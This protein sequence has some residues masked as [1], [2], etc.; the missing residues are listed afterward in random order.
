MIAIQLR[1]YDS[2]VL[3]TRFELTL[4]NVTAVVFTALASEERG[5][6]IAQVCMSVFMAVCVSQNVQ[7]I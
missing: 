5:N 1:T 2:N 6:V 7:R 3:N 4:I